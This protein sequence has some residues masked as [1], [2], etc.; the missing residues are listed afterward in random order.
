MTHS[1]L[2]LSYTNKRFKGVKRTRGE[3]GGTYTSA[4]TGSESATPSLP[5]GD[6]PYSVS[7]AT[8]ASSSATI[9]TMKDTTAAPGGGSRA[10][11]EV[12]HQDMSTRVLVSNVIPFRLEEGLPP[13]V[14]P[15]LFDAEVDASVLVGDSYRPGGTQGKVNGQEHGGAEDTEVT[16]GSWARRPDPFGAGDIWSHWHC[17]ADG[18]NIEVRVRAGE[19]APE[20][21][22]R[23]GMSKD[24]SALIVSNGG[25][26][27][28]D[29]E[30]GGVPVKHP[31]GQTD[32]IY[33]DREIFFLR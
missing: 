32:Q 30:S 4:S 13:E 21:L 24:L 33:S 17:A 1:T 5:H 10:T 22:M 9:T 6:K 8:G 11:E 16:E 31:K 15:L 14:G 18:T 27:N 25:D 20:G 26:I 2:S 12:L 29:E 19:L 28:Q 3:A 23:A 7:T